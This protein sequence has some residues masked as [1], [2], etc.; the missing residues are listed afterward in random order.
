MSVV[1]SAMG[2]DPSPPPTPLYGVNAQQTADSNLA[3]ARAA[4]AANRIDQYTPY[5]NIT[6]TSGVNGNP[7]QWRSDIT[8]SDTGQKLLDQ[9][10]AMALGLGNLG[11]SGLDRV[12]QS[13]AKPFDYGS[14]QDVQDAAYA[15]Q[16]ARLDPQ[17]D[18]QEKQLQSRLA[19]QGIPVGS[20]AWQNEMRAFN[21]AKTD[22]YSQARMNAIQTAPQTL[23]LATSLREQPLNELNALRTGAQVTNPQFQQAGQQQTTAGANFLGA[24]GLQGQYDMN[25]YNQRVGMANQDMAGMFSLAQ[26]AMANSKIG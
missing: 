21:N 25:T 15:G 2:K 19:N 10:N 24:S 9:Q 5:G 20:E 4:T 26:Q 7:D 3:M 22:A 6:Y 18:M 13:F 16:T 8:L 12:D 1:R 14:V 17:W 11:V 23:Q